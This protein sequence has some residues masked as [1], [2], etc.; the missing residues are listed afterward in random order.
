MHLLTAGLG[1][2]MCAHPSQVQ[3]QHLY[4]EFCANVHHEHTSLHIHSVPDHISI[5]T[6]SGHA[7]AVAGSSVTWQ[8]QQLP[9]DM[10]GIFCCTVMTFS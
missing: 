8:Q 2:D 9:N 5:C 6:L 1:Y 3:R 7:A 4:H 10:Q